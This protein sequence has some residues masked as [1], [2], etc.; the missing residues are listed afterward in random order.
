MANM[1]RVFDAESK[2]VDVLADGLDVDEHDNLLLLAH[3]EK[4]DE[5]VAV[6]PRGSYRF[7]VKLVDPTQGRPINV[8][9][10]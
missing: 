4:D 1:Y 7:V 5:V 10:K 3:H 9:G 8:L 6:F 2:V